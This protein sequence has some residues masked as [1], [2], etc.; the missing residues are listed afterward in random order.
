[1]SKNKKQKQTNKQIQEEEHGYKYDAM[2]IKIN[3][4]RFFPSWRPLLSG[5][6]YKGFMG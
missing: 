5:H 4:H 2:E 6:F 1:M 3:K